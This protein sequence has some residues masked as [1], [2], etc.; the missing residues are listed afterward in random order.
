MVSARWLNR[1]LASPLT[2]EARALFL[3]SPLIPPS[4]LGRPTLILRDP[5]HGLISF[6]SDEYRIVSDL[7]ETKELQRLRRIRQLGLTS[8]AYPGADH[9]RF[10]HALGTAHVMRLFIERLR[11]IHD[12]L[13]YWQR[14]T[15]ERAR[16]ALAAALLHDIGHGPFSHL[17]EEALP[18]G[19]RH[20]HWTERLVLDPATEV[21]RVLKRTD[22]A[23]PARV[24]E[25]IA[26]RHPL[27]YLAHTVSG[28]FDV[29]RCDYLL[30]DALFTGVNYGRYDLD[31]LLRSLR[32]GEPNG[33]EVPPLAVDGAKGIPAIESFVLARLFMFQ[34]VYFH[35]ASRSSEWLLSR[36]LQ[37]VAALLEDGTRLPA[38]P[39]GV[40]SLALNGDASLGQYLALDDNVMWE[41]LRAWTTVKDPILA[42]LSGRL[43]E[44]RLFKTIELF[45]DEAT[46]E[47]YAEWHEA[48]RELAD[49]RGLDPDV[50][51]GLDRS[52]L[53]PLDDS[54]GQLWV[55]FPDGN[56]KRL[57]EV[58]FVLS[59]LQN[60]KLHKVRLIY[61]SEIR[62]ELKQRMA[63]TPLRGGH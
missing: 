44:R 61:P 63:K 5:V 49:E 29:D 56:K 12:G 2:S 47:M 19:P 55:L 42:D 28:T 23:M 38:T 45:G 18:N 32:I 51:V 1:R 53:S 36:V 46:P 3:L 22:P 4:H 54:H 15:T 26:G 14:L 37:R 16:D 6:E 58:S 31:W 27:T 9:T 7:L 50:Y 40:S 59:R 43:Y 33:D 20:E 52:T 60:E 17:F 13:P 48:A 21:H 39:E 8:F 11:K 35:K 34:Q 62:T 10:S 30:R 57:P 41:A 25:L 24:S